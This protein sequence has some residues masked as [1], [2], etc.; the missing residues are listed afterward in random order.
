VQDNDWV[1]GGYSCLPSCGFDMARA[2]GR[3]AGGGS[4]REVGGGERARRPCHSFVLLPEAMPLFLHSLS[5]IAEGSAGIW[6]EDAW[7]ADRATGSRRR[8]K[9]NARRRRPG[10]GSQWAPASPPPER[11]RWPVASQ[12][13]LHSC[14]TTHTFKIR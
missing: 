1:S 3:E 7:V 2:L 14:R 5:P 8:P 4:G 12:L 13:S 10:S 6:E 9:S 11:G